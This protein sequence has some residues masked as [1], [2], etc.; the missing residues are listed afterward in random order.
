MLEKVQHFLW[1]L[2]HHSLPFRLMLARRHI[3][4]ETKCLVCLRTKENGGHCYSK[5]KRLKHLMEM[6]EMEEV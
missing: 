2:A 6:G 3:E 1:R 4:L 5:W